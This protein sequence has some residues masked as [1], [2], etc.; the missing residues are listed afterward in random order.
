MCEVFANSRTEEDKKKDAEA[1]KKK[2]ERDAEK[3]W[4]EKNKGNY[5]GMKG[6]SKV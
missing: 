1:S 4:A 3:E 6:S 2:K 5:A